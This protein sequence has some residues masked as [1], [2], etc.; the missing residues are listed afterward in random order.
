MQPMP[1]E[2]P[3][4]T[5]PGTPALQNLDLVPN[6]EFAGAAIDIQNPAKSPSTLSRSAN[7]FIPSVASKE[8]IKILVS[9]AYKI[10]E[11]ESREYSRAQQK[12]LNRLKY[13]LGAEMAKLDKASYNMLRYE[14]NSAY[15]SS[16]FA[17]LKWLFP[18]DFE[19]YISSLKCN[20]LKFNF[21][22]ETSDFEEAVSDLKVNAST[23]IWRADVIGAADDH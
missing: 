11:S 22:I 5:I 13:S 19:R 8:I 1:E 15:S 20:S 10:E 18:H 2:T 23:E 3:P 14:V 21:G 4:S 6:I 12:E 7:E 17:P 16:T 9:L